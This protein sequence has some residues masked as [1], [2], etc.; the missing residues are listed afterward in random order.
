MNNFFLSLILFVPSIVTSAYVLIG[1]PGNSAYNLLCLMPLTYGFCI[2]ASNKS[3]KNI[4]YSIIYC[5]FIFC[6]FLK[7]VIMPIFMTLSNYEVFWGYYT[8]YISSA[9]IE[10]VMPEAILIMCYDNICMFLA[11]SYIYSRNINKHR[12][13]RRIKLING[14]FVYYSSVIVMIIVVAFALYRY[15]VLSNSVG[16]IWKNSLAQ[17]VGNDARGESSTLIY[18]LF[19]WFVDMLQ[20]LIPITLVIRIQKLKLRNWIK[21]IL[22]FTVVFFTL[23][24][25]TDNKI[26]SIVY[27]ILLIVWYYKDAGG[28]PI[29]WMFGIGGI[30]VFAF[31]A[32]LEKNLFSMGLASSQLGLLSGT[33]NGYFSGPYNVAA[34]LLLRDELQFDVLMGDIINSIPFL[35]IFFKGMPTTKKLFNYLIK[36]FGAVETKIMPLIGQGCFYLTP[37]LGPLFTVIVV[38]LAR[39]WELRS[40][41]S[42]DSVESYIFSILAVF[43]A[44][45]PSVFNG[46]ILIKNVCNVLIVKM[47][48]A[49]RDE[50]VIPND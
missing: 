17:L 50:K 12:A 16:F 9:D 6:A 21:N 27:A 40:K 23:A 34:S 32:L 41:E 1:N 11:L 28:I 30:G 20:V 4:K 19:I 43:A 33:L 31:I 18:R 25:M 8:S 10:A 45:A 7:M 37:I 47:L 2:F 5:I 26:F 48:V 49:F 39:K 44:L 38:A 35:P 29:K 14:S 46:T 24:I 22:F 36:G 13:Q 15:P 3:L 42:D